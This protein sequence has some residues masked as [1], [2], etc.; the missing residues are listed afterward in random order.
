MVQMIIL[1]LPTDN[2]ASGNLSVPKEAD[3]AMSSSASTF[4][5]IALSSINAV[6]LVIS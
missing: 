5:I 3:A 1:W 6:V 4:M 2:G